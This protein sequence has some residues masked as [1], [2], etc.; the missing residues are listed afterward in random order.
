M[1]DEEND[2]V[3]TLIRLAGRRPGIDAER[4]ARVRAAVEGEWRATLRRRLWTRVGAAVALAAAVGGVLLFRSAPEAPV[5][6]P[7]LAPIV[8]HVQFV[9][10]T[11]APAADIRAGAVLQLP[12]G[13]TASLDWNGATLRL[14]GGT[15]LRF[16]GAEVATLQRGAVYYAGDGRRAA[17]TLRTLFGDVR[18]VGTRFEVRL[19]D[20]GVVVRVREGAVMLRGTTAR[21]RSELVATASSI[22]TRSIGTTGEAWSWIEEAAPPIT[23]EGKTLEDVMRYVA[24]E[25]G[26]ALEW[27]AGEGKRTIR[28]HGDV[29]LTTSEALDAATI[30]AGVRYRIDGD[31]L[32]VGRHL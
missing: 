25:K 19:R 20:D 9:R 23:L 4:T 18:D 7:A 16:D 31:R 1:N 15:H 14:D 10:G 28:L 26:L 3:A 12:A 32:I 30:A 6:P 24:A 8:A 17:V 11:T 21:A 13:A 27:S 2:P 5:A 22:E 29:P